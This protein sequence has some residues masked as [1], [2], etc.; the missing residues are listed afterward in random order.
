MGTSL[1]QDLGT[2][3]GLACEYVEHLARGYFVLPLYFWRRDSH[4]SDLSKD[5]KLY[6]GDPLL[7]TVAHERAPGLSEDVAAMVENA[8]ALSL[9]HRYEPQES[10]V[11]G[12]DT[13][14]RLHVWATGSGGEV[15]FVCGPYRSVA[16]VEVKHRARIDRRSIRGVLRALPD[17]PVV[18]ATKDTLEFHGRHA[19]IPSSLL[20]WALG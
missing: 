7:Y 5:K 16:A 9:L 3:H 8:A 4:S 20:L 19:L 13:V 10:L 17:R 15:D 1:A 12:F 14:E 18:F 11:Q 2:G 6:F